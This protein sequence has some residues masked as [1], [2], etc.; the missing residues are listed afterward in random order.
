MKAR[1]TATPEDS[2][3]HPLWGI[4]GPWLLVL[5]G[6][7]A[8]AVGLV[9]PLVVTSG[10]MEPGIATGD[11]LLAARTPV[12]DVAVGDVL[13]VRSA[14]TDSFVTHRVTEVAPTGPVSAELRLRGDANASED[15]ETYLVDGAV[16]EPRVR[17][18]GGGRVVATLARPGV[19]VPLLVAIGALVAMTLVPA[20]GP[21]PCEEV[22]AP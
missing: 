14:V 7:G 1:T 12:A 6:W 9:Q 13:T 11:L 4:E 21:A 18:P 2:P 15:G 16:W 3:I 5:L 8:S 17:V 19:A 10:S 22:H 20:R